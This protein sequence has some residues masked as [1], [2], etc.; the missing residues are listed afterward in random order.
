MATLLICAGT[1]QSRLR[2]E[3]CAAGIPGV[4]RVH[5]VADLA[6]AHSV[7]R[8]QAPDVVLLDEQLPG[9]GA[10]AIRRV[11]A[12]NPSARVFLLG[13]REDYAA[14]A[15]ALS[16]GAIGILRPDLTSAELAA[17]VAHAVLRRPRADSA[18]PP[19]AASAARAEGGPALTERELQ[20]LH[21]MADGKSNGE[22]GRGLYLSE[23]TVKT[24]AQRLFRKLCVHDRAQAV[25]SGFRL[26]LVS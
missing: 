13:S 4:A 21:G 14:M 10:V 9:A 5:S 11:A 22:I 20:V 24:H 26:G 1:F 19:P 15:T 17:A 3:R 23:D 18:P 12:E 25:A 8:Q 16:A 2:L 7:V 6:Q